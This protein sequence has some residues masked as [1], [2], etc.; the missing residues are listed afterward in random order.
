MTS[1]KQLDANRR[2][3]LSNTDP[4]TPDGAI[5]LLPREIRSG[6]TPV[7]SLILGLIDSIK[8]DEQ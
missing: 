7:N 5:T 8:K 6:P 4:K 2:N 3:A 1:D